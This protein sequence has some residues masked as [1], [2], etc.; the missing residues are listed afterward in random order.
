M[1]YAV[2]NVDIS[3]GHTPHSPAMNPVTNE[4]NDTP[5]NVKDIVIDHDGLHSNM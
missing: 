2:E 3:P 4:L 5:R 1:N